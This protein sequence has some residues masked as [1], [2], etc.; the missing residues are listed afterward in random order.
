MSKVKDTNAYF[1]VLEWRDM[2][3]YFHMWSRIS[4]YF[5]SRRFLVGIAVWIG[6]F[7]CAFWSLGIVRSAP[8]IG[9][10]DCLSYS[11]L[12]DRG[13]IDAE[14]EI[15]IT[16]EKIDR[17]MRDISRVTSCIRT[18][19]STEG[20]E[21]IPA[22]AAKYGI[23]VMQG[24]WID[25]NQTKNVHE[26]EN[27]IML[28]NT[29]HNVTHLIVGNEVMYFHRATELYLAALIEDAKSRVHIPVTTGEIATTLEKYPFITRAVDFVMIHIFPYYDWRSVQLGSE[30]FASQVRRAQMLY[31]GKE[32]MVW[33]TAW[34]ST[35]T[36]RY[37]AYASIQSQ[38]QYSRSVTDFCRQDHTVCNFIE[39]HDQPWKL[40]TEGRRGPGYGYFDMLGF[41]K[42]PLSG[43]VYSHHTLAIFILALAVFLFSSLILFRRF[44]RVHT[45]SL[46]TTVALITVTACLLMMTL[47][48]AYREY[49]IFSAMF[50]WCILPCMI[51]WVGLF[52]HCVRI[53]ILGE[54]A[55]SKTLAIPSLENKYPFVS[56]H[57]PARSEDPDM[58]IRTIQACQWLDYPHF[59]VLII[60]NN[61]SDPALWE[62]VAQYV[63]QSG[64]KRVHFIHREHLSGYKSWALNLALA[65][66]GSSAQ[67]IA[68][69]DADYVVS[70]NWLQNT[71]GYFTDET[72]AA[73]QCPQAHGYD[74][75]SGLETSMH[76][77]LD[78]F[79]SHGMPARAT[80]NSLIM[81]GTMLLLRRDIFNII[82]WWDEQHIC[83]DTE[84]GLR[85]LEH[86]YQ[87]VY[88]PEVLGVGYLPA[89]YIAFCRQRFRWVF[90][91]L[92]IARK[93]LLL[94]WTSKMHLSQCL[95]YLF[96]W[97][98]WWSQILYP[99]FF[100]ITGYSLYRIQEIYTQQLPYEFVFAVLISG[101]GILILSIAVHRNIWRSWSR[102]WSASL[103]STSLIPVIITAVITGLVRSNYP[104][105]RTDK[106]HVATTRKTFLFF[107]NFL[108]WTLIFALNAALIVYIIWC[109]QAYGFRREIVTWGLCI[110]LFVVAT[111][112]RYYYT[113]WEQSEKTS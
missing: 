89:S 48:R 108:S 57:I 43:A 32:V 97:L 31:P 21:L 81:H 40:F 75:H 16:A 78:V 50:A 42:Y 19:S 58:L 9:Y 63:L 94:M 13:R 37:D 27:G 8:S 17:D 106:I 79:F 33:E 83:E 101:F 60:D 28:A 51:L 49:Y 80:T 113:L 85:I 5:L 71:M 38:A 39:S 102:A 86:G 34:P 59:E 77:E 82:W 30:S 61:T 99:I 90:G 41:P 26:Y 4:P 109:F 46:W 45:A 55:R 103:I 54:K 44:S 73:V 72:I 52:L 15:N 23:R 88:H 62:P 98:L 69:L 92:Q 22:I 96:G 76:D 1:P 68:L 105:I 56:I 12:G 64:D 111:L 6:V 100:I 107:T 20:H 65:H 53:F 10:F 84:L 2:V 7:A 36:P 70:A 25:I 35:G 74:P 11:P 91:S 66:T 95:E 29:Y 14:T 24:I 104:F 47:D 110:I 18:Y 93:H 112:S 87:I 3:H 67:I